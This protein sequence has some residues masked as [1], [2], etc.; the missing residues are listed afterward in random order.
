[1]RTGKAAAS[2]N[3]GGNGIRFRHAIRIN[4]GLNSVAQFSAASNVV[5]FEWFASYFRS[6]FPNEAS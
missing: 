1:M 6:Q 5:S 4:N 3:I 2:T